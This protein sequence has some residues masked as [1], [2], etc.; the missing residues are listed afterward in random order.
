MTKPGDTADPDKYI[1][2][3]YGNGFDRSGQFTYRDGGTGRNVVIFGVDS[4]DIRY[5]AMVLFIK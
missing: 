5:Q 3:G 1:Y 4:S 2:S